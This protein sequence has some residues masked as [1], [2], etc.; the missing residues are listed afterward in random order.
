MTLWPDSAR[1]GAETP[2]LGSLADQD[3]AGSLARLG[4]PPGAAPGGGSAPMAAS[5]AGGAGSS[6]ASIEGHAGAVPS[7]TTAAAG[8]TSEFVDPD[9]VP[10]VFKWDNGG[11]EVYV[12]GTFTG[13]TAHR[14]MHRSGNDFTY[15]T[16]LPR[17]L[18]EYKFIVDGHWR[19]AA[20]QEVCCATRAS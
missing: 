19:W 5:G 13:W 20:E 15:M 3:P 4:Q 10:T 1:S 8:H 18:H 17:G 12:T 7:S 16:M 11:T 14:R 2:G 6:S 9:L